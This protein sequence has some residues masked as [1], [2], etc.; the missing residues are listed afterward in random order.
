MIDLRDGLTSS[1]FPLCPSTV[2]FI[3]MSSA[4]HLPFTLKLYLDVMMSVYDKF[5]NH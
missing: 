2:T 1:Q 5:E 3:T 4:Y